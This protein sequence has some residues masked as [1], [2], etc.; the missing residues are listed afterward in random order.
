MKLPL[1]ALVCLGAF[2][3]NASAQLTV[4]KTTFELTESSPRSSVRLNN[5]GADTL[6]VN[7]EIEELLNPAEDESLRKPIDLLANP[8]MLVLPQQL[9][10][11]PG[12]TKLVRVVSTN[13]QVDSDKVY[14]LNVVPFAGKPLLGD[15]EDKQIGVRILLGYKLLI[16]VRPESISPKIEY[17]QLSNSLRFSNTGNTSVLLREIVAC[18]TSGDDCQNLSANRVYPGEKYSVELPENLQSRA[19]KVKTRQYI[20]YSEQIVEY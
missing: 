8:D 1:L 12:Q 5:S 15:V 20:R 17:T 16:L 11:E 18:N 14:R 10:L 2:A 13:A 3:S 9:V 19:L 4:S 6:Y 7:L